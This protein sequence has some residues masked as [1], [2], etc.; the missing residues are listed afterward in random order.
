MPP[1]G[2]AT[3][4]GDSVPVFS[5]ALCDAATDAD[6]GGA[7]DGAA[8]A[9][10]SSGGP[11]AVLA[12]DAA[13]AGRPGFVPF[14]EQRHRGGP[15]VL[16][17]GGGAPRI[18]L[19]A[20]A[21]MCVVAMGADAE[22]H[23]TMAACLAALR[24]VRAPAPPTSVVFF[25]SAD[26]LAAVQCA[27]IPAADVLVSPDFAVQRCAFYARRG[28]AARP[29]A[30]QW[31]TLS[32]SDVRTLL[33]LGATAGGD[34]C[35]A[36]ALAVLVGWQR[37]G[38]TPA[39]AAACDQLAGACGCR[40]EGRLGCAVAVRVADLR[41]FV[42]AGH[43]AAPG[44]ASRGSAPGGDR[45][46][47]AAVLDAAAVPRGSL[48]VVDLTDPMLC[49]EFACAVFTVLMAQF[50][51]VAD[52]TPL[53]SEGAGAAPA[54][55]LALEGAHTTLTGAPGGAEP[56]A[57][58]LMSAARSIHTLPA[59]VAGGDT[60]VRCSLSVLVSTQ[61]P[62]VLP[63]DLMD[64]AT[65]VLLHR[66]HSR[67]WLAWLAYKLPLGAGAEGA[68]AGLRPLG[69][70]EEAL[71]Y[72][73]HHAVAAGA[74]E[75]AGEELGD[76]AFR[77][78]LLLPRAHMGAAAT[79]AP[80]PATPPLAAP[81]ALVLPALLPPR[82]VRSPSERVGGSLASASECGL[83]DC[84]GPCG[85]APAP[86]LGR[87]FGALSSASGGSVCSSGDG[88]G[89]RAEPRTRY[90]NAPIDPAEF[91]AEVLRLLRAAGGGPV[92]CSNL[93]YAMPERLRPRRG[94]QQ[95]A[96][97]VPGVVIAVGEKANASF[98]LTPEAM[99]GDAPSPVAPDARSG[100]AAGGW[101][102]EGEGEGEGVQAVGGALQ[103]QIEALEPLLSR[104]ITGMIL[105]L[106]LAE[107]AAVAADGA[108]LRE[109]V[110][111]AVAELARAGHT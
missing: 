93:A 78:R 20:V 19:N 39:M 60:S 65:L 8:N 102:G 105:G 48:V 99:R 37:A 51:G 47:T 100:E 18:H 14:A 87:S 28:V 73:P 52:D 95:R 83:S 26:A 32:A 43:A 101:A 63:L 108:R 110:A 64:V 49:G 27:S 84:G 97:E 74:R 13:A 33:R 23:G 44:A 16:F 1:R 53:A 5:D 30:L 106:G 24:R 42:S 35:C 96:A 86:D 81:S 12:D 4:A 62:R 82:H 92:M 98:S 46:A 7:A 71:L 54:L 3:P 29:L 104:K 31:G 55:V 25:Y 88:S 34:G 85:A 89:P 56:L 58:A 70:G 36:A 107:A 41:A 40:A 38:A 17:A 80:A 57:E 75:R 109:L 72:A 79:A 76:A 111:E 50:R 103:A 67:D 22:C 9:G 2:V 59:A 45:V 66:L 6:G 10:A 94:F 69:G 61:L 68:L 91:G 15:P 11:V 77:V 21:P 90:S